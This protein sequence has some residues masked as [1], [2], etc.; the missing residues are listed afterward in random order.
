MAAVLFYTASFEHWETL[1]YWGYFFGFKENEREN[2]ARGRD[3]SREVRD[4]RDG[5]QKR[6]R[7][8]SNDNR[9]PKRQRLDERKPHSGAEERTRRPESQPDKKGEVVSLLSWLCYCSDC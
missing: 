4:T 8:P 7:S 2:E 3:V 5:S 9:R 1:R 6:R